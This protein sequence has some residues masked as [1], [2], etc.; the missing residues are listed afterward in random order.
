MGRVTV[1]RDTARGL[2]VCDA[3]TTVISLQSSYANSCQVLTISIPSRKVLA[4]VRAAESDSAIV[5]RSD[6]VRLVEW[7]RKISV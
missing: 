5:R 2:G 7:E 4:K 3:E 1:R 6:I